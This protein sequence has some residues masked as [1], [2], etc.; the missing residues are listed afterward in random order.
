MPRT[1]LC[2]AGVALS[3]L[4]GLPPQSSIPA[5]EPHVP[6]QYRSGALPQIPI[7]AVGGGEVLLEV[8]VSRDGVLTGIKVLRATPPFTNALTAAVYGWEFT[9]A[10][11]EVAPEPGAPAGPKRRARVD[12]K[13]LVAGMFRAPTL[14]TPT[15]GE[16]PKNVAQASDETP[17]PMATTMPVYPPRALFNGIVLIEVRVAPAGGVVG[18]KVVSSAPPFDGPALD[19]ARQWTFRPARVHGTAVEKLAYIAF[20]FPQPITQR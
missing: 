8:S 17:S 14:N 1:I 13:V 7:L 16:Q 4:T 18:A 9:P 3:V 11:E 12:S 5:A 2:T 6:A 20:A 19:A 10:E 15:L